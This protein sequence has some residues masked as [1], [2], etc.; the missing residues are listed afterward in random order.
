MRT[1]KIKASEATF[2]ILFGREAPH[3]NTNKNPN[4]YAAPYQPIVKAEAFHIVKLSA[5]IPAYVEFKFCKE[6]IYSGIT[7]HVSFQSVKEHFEGLYNTVLSRLRN[8][9]YD[10]LKHLR[11]L[12]T[13]QAFNLNR[14]AMPSKKASKLYEHLQQAKKDDNFL[15]KYN[16]H[17]LLA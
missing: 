15:C 9:H 16:K 1:E 12:A 8:E 6:L 5:N 11:L 3:E 4:F 2:E 7:S 17:Q 13:E 10:P 14:H